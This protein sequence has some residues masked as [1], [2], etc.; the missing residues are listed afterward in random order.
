MSDANWNE[1]EGTKVISND[2]GTITFE[3]LAI[4]PGRY[5]CQECGARFLSVGDKKRH[6][7]VAH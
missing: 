6:R 7:K 4:E 2:D 3:A 5:V 1:I